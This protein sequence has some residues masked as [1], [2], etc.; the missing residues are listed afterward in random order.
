M[1]KQAERPPVLAD[2]LTVNEAAYVAEVSVK[3]ANQAI[4]RKQ[5]R[6]RR[7]RR[8]KDRNVRG[9]GVSEVV[10]LRVHHVLAPEIRQRFYSW[11][12]GKDM[13]ELPRRLEVDDVIIDLSRAIDQVSSRLDSL[14]RIR[15]RVEI[16]RDVRGGEPVFRGTRIPVYGVARKLEAGSSAEELLED[17]PPL[18]EEDLSLA[19]L[20]TRLYPRPG[21]PH[22]E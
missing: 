5:I 21:R 22:L 13:S 3:A 14:R 4:D 19:V 16:A 17:H 18:R 8:G 12:E 10:Y 2:T 15:G 9:V 7:L 20:Y 6:S 1:A 11:L